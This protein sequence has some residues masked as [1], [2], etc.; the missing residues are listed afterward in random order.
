MMT[1]YRIGEKIKAA[2]IKKG[3]TQKELGILCGYDKNA[4]TNVRKWELNMTSV[5]VDRL[6]RLAAALDLP[7]DDL[8]P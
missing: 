3:L 2:R 8:I 1:S 4:D 7:L 6:R 5:P